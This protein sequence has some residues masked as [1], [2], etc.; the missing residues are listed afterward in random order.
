MNLYTQ[1]TP[2]KFDPLSLNEVMMVPL[3]K[4]KMHD[5]TVKASSDE[6]NRLYQ[7]QALEPHN[8]VVK[9][10]IGEL[11]TGLNSLTQGITR[12]GINRGYIDQF[13]KLK[14]TSDKELS[15]QGT[16]GQSNLAYA[17]FQEAKNTSLQNMVNQGYDPISAEKN[18]NKH[19]DNYK[20]QFLETGNIIPIENR[21]GLL[22]QDLEKEV[23][24]V[25]ARLGRYSSDNQHLG[26]LEIADVN[27]ET[28]LVDNKGNKVAWNDNNINIK[29]AYDALNTKF[30]TEGGEGYNYLLDS[31]KDVESAKK[32][33]D[34][35]LKSYRIR[36]DASAQDRNITHL[37]QGKGS[38][39]GSGDEI[40]DAGV[41]EL[42]SPTIQTE[43][44]YNDARQYN[45]LNNNSTDPITQ[46]Q[47]KDN[48]NRIFVANRKLA[49]DPQFSGSYLRLINEDKKLSN[50]FKLSKE[51]LQM[52]NSTPIDDINFNI[53]TGLNTEFP[54]A[55]REKVRKYKQE[56][57]NI[58]QKIDN[59][60]EDAYSKSSAEPIYFEINRGLPG[61]VT[62]S[63][64]TMISQNEAQIGNRIPSLLQSQTID[65]EGYTNSDG[66]FIP[67][68]NGNTKV[69]DAFSKILNNSDNF[70]VALSKSGINGAPSLML[71]FDNKDKSD[72]TS[73]D[74]S[75]DWFLDDIPGNGAKNTIYLNLKFLKDNK[76]ANKIPNIDS[77][78]TAMLD[79]LENF[80]GIEGK[81]LAN[82]IKLYSKYQHIKP[83]PHTSD[84]AFSNSNALKNAFSSNMYSKAI[85]AGKTIDV[86]PVVKYGDQVG[87]QLYR[88]PFNKNSK[89]KAVAVTWNDVL[90]K[91]ALDNPNTASVIPKLLLQ[92]F[93][94]EF[95]QKMSEQGITDVS[96][97]DDNE[98][99]KLI[100][101]FLIDSRNRPVIFNDALDAI[102]IFQ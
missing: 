15:P 74:G 20:N 25:K 94:N 28:V 22:K 38:G 47:L 81:A 78:K 39:S 88:K 84:N 46:R 89:N 29:N 102:N 19:V 32:Y 63:A 8:E 53:K 18:W 21:Q 41:I 66:E 52:A 83:V 27:G 7:V 56:K 11:E 62:Q 71:T 98:L 1:L 26:Q 31:G 85:F 44:T 9:S 82:E 45:A 14:S 80:G 4:Q 42:P 5:D 61:A 70:K 75:S 54:N 50:K 86:E 60:K 99:D 97:I 23:A 91:D 36:E 33:T 48:E 101:Q 55:D 35:M 3:A 2:A 93:S 30:F 64:K 92:K 65:V 51:E 95:H 72:K 79:P 100:S 49:T 58:K 43:G 67:I 13:N 24:D 16:L 12:E 40:K 77:L 37:R 69:N 57:Y 73:I 68:K 96:R 87:V 10:K 17:K 59:L 76:L 90:T 34:S 6:L